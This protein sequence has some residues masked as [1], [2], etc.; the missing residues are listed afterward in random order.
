LS[1]PEFGRGDRD[2]EVAGNPKPHRAAWIGGK[3]APSARPVAER[4]VVGDAAQ[5]AEFRQQIIPCQNVPP[6][7][8]A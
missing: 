8:R 6:L 3:Q 5:G 2:Q 1:V 4:E 7:L